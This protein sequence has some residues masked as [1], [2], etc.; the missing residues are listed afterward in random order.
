MDDRAVDHR[1]M[2]GDT[3]K[4]RFVRLKELPKGLLG[5]NLACCRVSSPEPWNHESC[6]PLYLESP[7]AS[8]PS[9]SHLA[10]STEF[11]SSSVYLSS[12][13]VHPERLAETHRVGGPPGPLMLPLE[14]V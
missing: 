13:Q 8:S 3:I 14:A 11:Q 1:W 5:E 7:G 4:G 9:S 10:K 12:A 2:Y 6:L